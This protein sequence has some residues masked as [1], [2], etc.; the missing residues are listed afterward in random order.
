MEYVLQKDYYLR[1]YFYFYLTL[2]LHASTY[3]YIFL[4]VTKSL[5]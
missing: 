1:N 2:Q 5:I 3:A 4:E